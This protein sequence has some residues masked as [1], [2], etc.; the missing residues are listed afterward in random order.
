[1]KKF[2]DIILLPESLYRKITGKKL[3][4]ILGILFV[5]I[6]D[7]I[8]AIVG[9]FKTYFNS[10]DLSK[11]IYNT[12]LVILLVVIIGALDVIFFTVPMFD[13]FKRFKKGERSAVSNESDLFVRL[14][15][16]Y[17]IAHFLTLIPQIAILL[18]DNVIRTLNL[19]SWLLYVAFFIDFII[20]LWFS[21]AIGRGVNVIYRFRTIFGKLS[22]LILFIWNYVLS[23]ALSYA[24]TN[25]IIPLFKI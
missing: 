22:Y 13:L 2:L 12:A 8:F 4:L 18:Y 21:G 1:M 19:N 25:W 14:A 24:I 10:E 17:I 3:T 9:N 6:L 15:K 16:I 5:G 23:N 11:L 20:P 7:I